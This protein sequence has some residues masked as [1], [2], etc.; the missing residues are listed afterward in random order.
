M[1]QRSFIFNS[2]PKPP[3]KPPKN[4]PKTPP[5]P[6][7]NPHKTPPPEEVEKRPRNPEKA[8]RGPKRPEA[9]KRLSAWPFKAGCSVKVF[10][11][12]FKGRMLDEGILPGL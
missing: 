8:R 5:K 11:L 3:Q 10:C 4:P 6:T 7:Q 12:T 9:Q 1:R 2:C